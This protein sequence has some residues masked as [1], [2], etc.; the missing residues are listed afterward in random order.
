MISHVISMWFAAGLALVAMVLFASLAGCEQRRA[1][2]P[3]ERPLGEIELLSDAF[4]NG[5]AIPVRYTGDG[6]DISPPL[7]WSSLPEG[8]SE[9]A[10]I[11]DDPDAP[12]PRPWVHWL[13]YGIPATSDRLAEAIAPGQ[14]M[15]FLG[16][17]FQGRNSSGGF[18]YRGPSP[19]RGHGTHH[20]HFKLY[21]LDCKL[22][23][24]PGADKPALLAAM[25]GHILSQGELVGTYER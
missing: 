18:G 4:A 12:L 19:P 6:E 1:Y 25:K 7:V 13:I 22:R 8:T 16:G 5:E 17:A 2:Q 20:Y 9:L 23:I 15:P 11:V 3:P 24:D 21:A 14:K 10:L